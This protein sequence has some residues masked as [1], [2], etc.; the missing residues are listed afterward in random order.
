MLES[1]ETSFGEGDVTE[2]ENALI[3]ALHDYTHI[4]EAYGRL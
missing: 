1:L 4:K 3:G 2:L